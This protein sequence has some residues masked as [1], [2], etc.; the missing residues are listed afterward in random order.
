MSRTH[1]MVVKDGKYVP[2]DGTATGSPPAGG[3]GGSAGAGT[4]VAANM[5]TW[6]WP[7]PRA[8]TNEL[9]SAGNTHAARTVMASPFKGL[10][11]QN[12]SAVASA[13]TKLCVYSD[14][15]TGLFP[16][17]LLDAVALDVS[18]SGVRSV[19]LSATLPAGK[20][21][22]AMW[23]ATSSD[24]MNAYRVEALSPYYMGADAPFKADTLPKC[25]LKLTGMSNPPDPWIGGAAKEA[26]VFMVQGA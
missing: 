21:W 15:T 2:W 22:F 8:I 18:A 4:L 23:S 16:D 11:I 19:A 14:S 10:A 17:R 6:A 20:Y 1:M 7:S 13:V 5:W 24:P 25:G 3:G 9:I 12:V 26:I